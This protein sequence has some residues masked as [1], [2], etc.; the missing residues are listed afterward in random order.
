[1]QLN[2]KIRIVRETK[3]WSQEDMAEKLSMSTTG[4]AKIERG[5]SMLN[6]QKL[7]RI[8]QIFEMDLAE[9]L[10]VSGKGLIYVMGD[11]NTST[12]A[13]NYYNSSQELLSE[14]EKLRLA[15]EYKDQLLAQQK[16][17]INTLQNLVSTLQSHD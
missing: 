14:I 2:E 4:Y 16:R 1:M 6:M 10:S 9:L 3:N 7:E 12:C 8:A 5:E 15:L 13:N 17:E 11:N